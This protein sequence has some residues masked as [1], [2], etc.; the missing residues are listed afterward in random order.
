[1]KLLGLNGPKQ[2]GKD[3]ACSYLQEWGSERGLLIKRRGFADLLKQ[4]AYRLFNPDAGIEESIV[5]AD[6]L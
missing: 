2:S 1:M 5:W 3:T 6:N 4:S